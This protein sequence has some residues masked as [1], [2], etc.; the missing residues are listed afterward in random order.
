MYFHSTAWILLNPSISN[1]FLVVFRLYLYELNPTLGL[2]LLRMA[3]LS[4]FLEKDSEAKSYIAAAKTILDVTHGPNS[5]FFL[6]N[7]VPLIR[8]I[9]ISTEFKKAMCASR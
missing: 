7:V 3:K 6:K 9:A 4:W 8:E 2:L 5:P 1:C